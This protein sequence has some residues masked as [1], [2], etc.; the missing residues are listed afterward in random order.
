MET[1][2]RKGVLIEEVSEHQE[3]KVKE[4]D[5]D[6]ITNKTHKEVLKRHY[7]IRIVFPPKF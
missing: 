6:I 2:P 3:K 5:V 7:F 1:H 4:R